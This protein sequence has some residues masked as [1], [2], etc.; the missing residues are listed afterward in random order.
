[1]DITIKKG[2]DKSKQ[3]PYAELSGQ[4]VGDYIVEDY[5]GQGGEAVVFLARGKTTAKHYA[6]KIFGL[7]DSDASRLGDA[8]PEAR[9]Q[10]SVEHA[11]VV[12]VGE[13]GL[14]DVELGGIVKSILYIPMQYSLLGN[15]HDV[16]PFKDAPIN[17][18]EIDTLTDLL[19]GL[20]AIHEK[21]ILHRDIKPANILRF[22]ER[23]GAAA[24]VVLKVTDFGMAKVSFAIAGNQ[25]R[26]SGLTPEYMAPE[27]PDHNHSEAGDI[28]S[29]GA[30][31]YYMING[32]D[33]ISGPDNRLDVHGWQKAHKENPR[34][35]A[36]DYNP[37][38]PAQLA[39]LIMRMM[40][41]NP[42][43]RPSLTECIETLDNYKSF[44]NQK[45]L[46][47]F[48][49]ADG[50]KAQ[51]ENG[52]GGHEDNYRI[53]FTPTFNA[54]FDPEV[55]LLCG[56]RLF[57]I[58]IQM[59]HPI[60]SEYRRLVEF[61]AEK[62]S[63]CFCMYEA[64]GSFD[65]H[66]FV[67]S[68]E[69][70][71]K[72]LRKDLRK[73][74]PA[75]ELHVNEAKN[76]NHLH[77]ESFRRSGPSSITVV[78]ALAV[79]EGIALAGVDRTDYTSDWKYPEDTPEHSIRAFTYV[80]A[81]TRASMDPAML[82]VAIVGSVRQRM[83]DLLKV[84]DSLTGKLRFPRITLIEFLPES[85]QLDQPVALVSFVATEYRFIQQL[86]TEIIELGGNAVKTSTFLETGRLVIQSDK[87]L[88]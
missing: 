31:L 33:P 7:D 62:F 68:D 79:Q 28:Y 17:T 37:R 41:V 73:Q 8:L 51:I 10:S 21:E 30:T 3:P 48:T 58:R 85:K 22:E 77:V 20:R 47:R 54:I 29:M 80:E 86:P 64:Y 71:V 60:F 43:E 5:I 82:T 34:P 9:T 66:A 14:A 6:L 42:A 27:Q 26:A 50:L 83:Q 74:F 13:P 75:S 53:R 35:N 57:V 52:H 63:D 19:D 46:S 36:M 40:S 56:A 78:G 1:M 59:E 61:M 4:E 12:T 81:V 87:V 45:A 39:L 76:V 15:C 67:W 70:R 23:R 44:L 32:Q 72:I 84:K 11:S 38:C 55:H 88:F 16:P 49:I 2:H 65:I 69:D 18:R 25:P 24:V